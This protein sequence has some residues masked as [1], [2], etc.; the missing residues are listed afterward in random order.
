MRS[1]TNHQDAI[2]VDHGN[3][4]VLERCYYD[5][6][7]MSTNFF[8]AVMH[9]DFFLT[10]Q[11]NTVVHAGVGTVRYGPTRIATVNHE[12]FRSQPLRFL[13]FEKS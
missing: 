6:V 9:H 7:T 13:K 1:I 3:A 5:G 2:T 8:C 4:T 10:R 11:K 12:P